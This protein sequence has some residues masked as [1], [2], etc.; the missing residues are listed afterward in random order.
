MSCSPEVVNFMDECYKSQEDR[1]ES[2]NLGGIKYT[3]V[4]P[5]E[6]S[7][8][9]YLNPVSGKK[10][11]RK[12]RIAL[13]AVPHFDDKWVVKRREAG[14]IPPGNYIMTC[15]V[16]NEDKW[17]E[18]L[19]LPKYQCLQGKFNKIKG[20]KKRYIIVQGGAPDNHKDLVNFI[21]EC[22]NPH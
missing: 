11:G 6:G 14:L 8:G 1:P 3:P 10:V 22:F 17:N 20:C 5:S 12:K 9:F 13:Y 18:L 21:R 19:K 2:Q 16:N 7:W 4:S 15:W